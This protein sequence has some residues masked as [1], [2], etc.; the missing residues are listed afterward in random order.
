GDA[1]QAYNAVAQMMSVYTLNDFFDSAIST[2]KEL[3]ALAEEATAKGVKLD[4]EELAEIED[5]LKSSSAASLGTGVKKKDLRAAL[6]LQALAVKYIDI[7]DKEIEDGVTEESILEYVNEH[8][9]DYYKADILKY[10]LSAEAK[11]YTDTVEYVRVE[12]LIDEYAEKL[13]AATSA[14]DFKKLVIEFEVEKGFDKN[15]DLNKG[16]IETPDET[17]IETAKKDLVEN[18]YKAVVEGETFVSTLT[19]NATYAE[20]FEAVAN[21]LYAT[22]TSAVANLDET[23]NYVLEKDDEA[24]AWISDEETEA[25]DTKLVEDKTED[26]Y[27]KTVYMMI[28]PMYLDESDTKD[29]AHILIKADEKTATAEQ[30]AAAKEKADKVLAEYKAGELTLEAFEKLAETYNEDSGCVYEGV[31]KGQMVKPFEDWTFDAARKVGDTGVVETEF[32]Y[33]VMY[34]VGEGGKAYYAKALDAY[35]AEE[36]E[37]RVDALVEEYVT[38]NDKAIAKKTNVADDTTAA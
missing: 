25:L 34:F 4:A 7:L 6:E 38:L 28:K 15:F 31:T 32:G 10:E 17:I 36:Y 16:S 37:D 9:E 18:I 21:N 35:I 27:A 5:T 26:K 33:H 19:D 20:P 1:T 3:V 13:A 24:L 11:N 30:K 14:E 23:E 12:K 22:C 8:K 29:V 2:S